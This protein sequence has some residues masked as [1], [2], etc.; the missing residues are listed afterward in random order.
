M[1]SWL[2]SWSKEGNKRL[3]EGAIEIEGK[4]GKRKSKEF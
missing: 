4:R 1:A 2:L 3:Q